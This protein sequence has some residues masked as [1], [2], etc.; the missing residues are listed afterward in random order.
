M[1]L[2]LI[3]IASL[4]LALLALNACGDK[5]SSSGPTPTQEQVQATIDWKIFLQGRSFPNPALV[6]IDGTEVINECNHKHRYEI[7][8][9][10]TPQALNLPSF[11][12]PSMSTVH[13]TIK[14]LGDCSEGTE[15][16]FMDEAAVTYEILKVGESSELIMNL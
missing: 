13:V 1:K 7:D 5:S 12:S 15:S 2:S 3:K 6:T 8:R 14:D 16:T 9:N 4:S 10:V 11:P